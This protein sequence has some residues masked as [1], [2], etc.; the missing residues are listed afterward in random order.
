MA[1]TG[2]CP[3]A[4]DSFVGTTLDPTAGPSVGEMTWLRSYPDV[5]EVFRSR[6]FVQGGGG[7]RDSAPFV[8]HGL[9]SLSGDEH[10]ERRRIESVLFRRSTLRYYET[11]VLAPALAAALDGCRTQ[12][13]ADGVVR[14]ELQRLL[15][16][17][18]HKV[19][20]TLVGLDAVDTPEATERFIRCMN[21]LSTGVNIEWASRDHREVIREALEYQRRF[22]AEFFEPSWRRREALV[23]EVEAGRR[24]ESDLPQDLITVLIRNREH[25]AQYDPGVFIREATL[26][27]G[28]ATN[29]IT[30]ALPHV[31]AELDGWVR[32]HP[33]DQRRLTDAEFLRLA[34][35][36]TLRLHPASPF[37]IRRAV[38]AARLPSGRAIEAGEYVVL[39][40]VSASRDPEVFG[41]DPDRFDLRR[42]PLVRVRPMAL[43][44]GGGPHTCIGMGM[45]VG[46][47][48]SSGSDGPMGIMVYALREL[49]R[50]GLA[51]DPDR[52]PRWN[53]TNVRN[54]YIE[55]PVR[56]DRL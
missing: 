35:A 49:Y 14:V 13:D 37:L 42:V 28:A 10:F 12:R 40:L 36:E 3:H 8:A 20:A 25:F 31:V 18:I 46:E 43:G 51:L 45:T 5:D 1:S 26:F 6:D 27:N 9:L 17:I 19:S 32:E 15:R 39:D 11:A 41:A 54:E 55:F 22:A 38:R 2:Q 24:P 16:A 29:T 53:D 33:E 52:P 56:F 44:F 34:I 4:S 21:E 30:L 23:A 47:A 7:R 48:G 50:A